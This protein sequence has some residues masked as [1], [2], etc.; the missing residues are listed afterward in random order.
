MAQEVVPASERERF[1][2]RLGKNRRDRKLARYITHDR[3]RGANVSKLVKQLLY[4]YYTGNPMPGYA[5]AIREPG[6]EDEV[7]RQQALSAKL[8]KL[9]FDV[10]HEG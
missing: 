2:V 3:H 5:G 7:V 9:S 1:Y 4:A 8:K 6:V 10:L